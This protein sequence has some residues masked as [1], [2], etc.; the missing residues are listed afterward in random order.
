[1][2]SRA[3]RFTFRSSQHWSPYHECSHTT[4]RAPSGWMRRHR[5]LWNVQ[6]GAV[7]TRQRRRDSN[8]RDRTGRRIDPRCWSGGN[9]NH[10]SILSP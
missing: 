2:T 7:V 8:H 1:M 4:R 3:T 6:R 5:N 10:R 9:E